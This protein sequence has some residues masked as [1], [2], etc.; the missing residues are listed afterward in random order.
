VHLLCNFGQIND[1]LFNRRSNACSFIFIVVGS[2][3]FNTF[4]FSN[5]A[6]RCLNY[7]ICNDAC[8]VGAI[9]RTINLIVVCEFPFASAV[10]FT[11]IAL[12][13]AYSDTSCWISIGDLSCLRTCFCNTDILLCLRSSVEEIK[14]LVSFFRCSSWTQRCLNRFLLVILYLIISK[15]IDASPVINILILLLIFNCRISWSLRNIISNNACPVRSVFS[16]IRLIIVGKLPL[17]CA[18]GF[19]VVTLKNVIGYTCNRICIGDGPCLRAS[20]CNALDL[21]RL[22]SSVEEIKNLVSLFWCFACGH[23]CVSWSLFCIRNF[24]Y[25][26]W[27]SIW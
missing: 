18:V 6:W 15:R 3:R 10:S 20:S 25:K 23:W 2:R 12:K 16:C 8:P 13:N 21:L 24:F 17:A 26:W 19:T 27:L 11:V 7:I 9:L 22:R 14:N 4:Q 1:I 5:W